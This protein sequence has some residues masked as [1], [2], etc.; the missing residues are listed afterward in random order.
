VELIAT[1]ERFNLRICQAEHHVCGRYVSGNY[2]CKVLGTLRLPFSL[3]WHAFTAVAIRE[4]CDLVTILSN[5]GCPPQA[6]YYLVL[7]KHAPLILV[8][9]NGNHFALLIEELVEKCTSVHS[10]LVLPIDPHGIFRRWEHFE[11]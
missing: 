7:L 2:Q 6:F 9:E 5:L 1:R 10:Q 11:A 4:L 3:R 8:I